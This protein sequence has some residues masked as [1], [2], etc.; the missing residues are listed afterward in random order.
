MGPALQSCG[1][2]SSPLPVGG[3]HR[4]PTVGW[5]LRPTAL[6]LLLSGPAVPEPDRAW[7]PLSQPGAGVPLG[8]LS[9]APGPQPRRAPRP[10]RLSHP[11]G[12]RALR[13]ARYC[14]CRGPMY[15]CRAEA[16]AQDWGSGATPGRLEGPGS[17]SA[18]RS[19][20]LLRQDLAGQVGS[21]AKISRGAGEVKGSPLWSLPSWLGLQVAL[22]LLC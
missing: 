2:P 15:S 16:E 3:E 19:T 4:V 6:L 9:A 11:A 5:R 18:K 13:Y 21:F 22:C 1:P 12:L 14:T 20:G 17:Q 8:T 10:R 7:E